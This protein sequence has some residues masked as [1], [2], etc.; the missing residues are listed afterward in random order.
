M[1]EIHNTPLVEHYEALCEHEVQWMVDLFHRRIARLWEV[2]RYIIGIQGSRFH[3]IIWLE[4][5]SLTC[6]KF[7]LDV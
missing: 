6:T 4:R 5:G 7:F 1:R 3:Y 2:F